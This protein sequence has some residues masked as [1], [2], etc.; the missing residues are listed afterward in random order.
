MQPDVR[1]AGYLWDMIDAAKAVRQFID[2]LSYE[3][4]LKDRQL[5]GAVERHVEIIGE[6][7]GRI[8]G[9]FREAH[10]EVVW[11]KIVA[12]RNVLAH[13]YGAIDHALMW[14]TVTVELP[15]LIA[16]LEVLLPEELE[17]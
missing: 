2:G 6:A 15:K 14:R 9:A 13:E 5:R 7:A 16:Q 11:R 12:Q 4:Y 3:D 1:D 8:S 17:N 10:K